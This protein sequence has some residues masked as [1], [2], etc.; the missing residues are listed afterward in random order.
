MYKDENCDKGIDVRNPETRLIIA[1]M[2]QEQPN[3]GRYNKDV[4]SE[5]KQRIT[6][7]SDAPA[8]LG[9]MLSP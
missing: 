6:L 3:S 5:Q 2:M 7:R 1:L 9:S 8:Q 4:L